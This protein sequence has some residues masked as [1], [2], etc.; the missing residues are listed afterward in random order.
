M[1][2]QRSGPAV[3]GPP[4][5]GSVVPAAARG[6]GGSLRDAR[7][8]S[9]QGTVRERLQVLRVDDD[10][11]EQLE[12]DGED[13]REGEGGNE[14]GT[15]ELPAGELLVGGRRGTVEDG[16]PRTV[17]GRLEALGQLGFLDLSQEAQVVLPQHRRSLL[18]AAWRLLAQKWRRTWIVKSG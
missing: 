4:N 8:G 18:E 13:H 17:L 14:A 2:G 10:R 12:Q 6:R 3:P 1:R 15:E 16:D 7:D 5:A 11:V 9:Q